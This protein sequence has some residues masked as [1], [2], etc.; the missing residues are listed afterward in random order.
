MQGFGVAGERSTSER[1]WELPQLMIGLI[2]LAIGLVMA[3]GAIR[4]GMESK[5]P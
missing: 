3:A 2:A 5:T 4:E 1:R